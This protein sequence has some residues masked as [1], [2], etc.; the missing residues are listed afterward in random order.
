MRKAPMMARSVH[1]SGQPSQ[2]QAPVLLAG[3]ETGIVGLS[4]EGGGRGGGGGDGREEKAN[5]I[6]M[7]GQCGRP[8]VC[9]P[10]APP[11][12]IRAVID[13][14]IRSFAGN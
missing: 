3:D 5:V 7:I 1:F 4:A 2:S 11:G 6:S 13:S 14:T 12:S 10:A 9:P 8:P